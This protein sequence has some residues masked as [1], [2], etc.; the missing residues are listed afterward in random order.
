MLYDATVMKR[1]TTRQLAHAAKVV[2]AL[3]GARRATYQCGGRVAVPLES[4]WS[5]VL[6][7]DDAERVRVDACRSGRVRATMW[8]LAGDDARLAE[9]AS[10]ARSE[11]AALAA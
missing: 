3:V 2:G 10:A 5:L 1:A 6:S 7:A 8:V 9:L 11:A 4:G